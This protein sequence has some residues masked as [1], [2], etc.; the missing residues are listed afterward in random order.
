MSTKIVTFDQ[1]E[2]KEKSTKTNT[3]LVQER[4]MKPVI[5]NYRTKTNISNR[6]IHKIIRQINPETTSKVNKDDQNEYLIFF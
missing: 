4:A 6:D 3:Q 2:Q 5:N 1:N